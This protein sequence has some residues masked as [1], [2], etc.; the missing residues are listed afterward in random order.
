MLALGI[1]EAINSSVAVAEDGRVI[2]AL[3]EERVNRIKNFMGFPHASLNFALRYLNL[4]PSDVDVV[5]L[6]NLESWLATKERFLAQCDAGYHPSRLRRAYSKTVPERVRRGLRPL[7][8]EDPNLVIERN[9]REHGLTR[10]RIVRS[11]HHR[12]H[13]AAAYF[14]LRLNPRDAHLVMTLDG[15]GDGMASHVYVGEEGCLRLLASTAAGHSLGNIYM[16]VTHLMGMTPHEDEYKLMGLAA[17]CDPKHAQPVVQIFQRYLDLDPHNPLQFKC[18]VAEGTAAIQPR[19]AADLVRIR[20]D[21]ITAG[22][23]FFAEDLM[24]RWIRNAVE[25][26]GIRKVVVAGGVFMNVKANKLI[27][28]LPELDYFDVFPSCGDESLPFGALWH[29]HA[30]NSPSRGDEIE[31]GGCNLGPDP[32]YDLEE[33]RAAFADRLHFTELE[34]VSRTTAELLARGHIVARCAGPME[35]GARALGN[36][37]ILADPKDHKVV[38]EINQMIKQRDFWMPFA[39]AVLYEDADKYLRIPHSL[40]PQR[41]SPWMMNTFETTERREEFE[42]GVH[43]YDK[44]ARA[45]IVVR[46]MNPQFHALIGEFSK[47]TQ[48]AIVLNTSFN[49][50]GHPLVMGAKDAMEVLLKSSLEYLT[51]NDTLITKQARSTVCQG[52][53][54]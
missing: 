43:A 49:L 13:A 18:R 26:T 27:S 5:C 24:V 29:H 7:L 21:R 50:H 42:A 8:R 23:Q 9:I 4:D 17:Y 1:N 44:T 35:F 16:F 2:F 11:H 36:R 39:P 28:E 40:P 45:Q 47:L 32:A 3:Q 48:R 38:H 37:S 15:E 46:R 54:P 14:G 31:F 25:Q 19:L 10:A 12:N 6:S 53:L 34:E 52:E 51:I 41:I 22:L 33:A 30:E 20:F